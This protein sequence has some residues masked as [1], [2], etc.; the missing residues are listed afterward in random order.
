VLAIKAETD[1]LYAIFLLEKNIWTNIR[2]TILRYPLMIAP[3]TLKE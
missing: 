3:E 2:K 1:D